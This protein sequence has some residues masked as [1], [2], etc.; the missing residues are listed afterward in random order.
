[1]HIAAQSDNKPFTREIFYHDPPIWADFGVI[2]G[3][4]QGVIFV[5]RYVYVLSI[6]RQQ[7]LRDFRFWVERDETFWLILANFD[8]IEIMHLSIPLQ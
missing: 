7:Y 5:V 8:Q 4:C 2:K 3:V 1:M 6:N